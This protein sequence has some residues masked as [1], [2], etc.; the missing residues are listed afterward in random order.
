MIRQAILRAAALAMLCPALPAAGCNVTLDPLYPLAQCVP[1]NPPPVYLWIGP[2]ADVP[3]SCP[4]TDFHRV[5]TF[6]GHADLVPGAVTCPE[7]ACGESETKCGVPTDW[8]VVARS[9]E[10]P[11]DATEVFFSGPDNWNGICSTQVKISA[12]L[13]CPGGEPCTQSLLVGPPTAEGAPCTPM[14]AGEITKEE[15]LWTW[16]TVALGCFEHESDYCDDGQ[17]LV[18]T[19]PNDFLLCIERIGASC[20]LKLTELRTVYRDAEDDRACAECTCEPPAGNLC[21]VKV[22]AYSDQACGTAAGSAFAS[23][24]EGSVCFDVPDGTALA[25]KRAELIET[26]PGTCTPGGGE[27]VGDVHGKDPVVFCCQPEPVY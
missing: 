19:V 7:C 3:A 26:T 8:T 23:S 20:P 5:K 17:I 21:S 25:S 18:Y 10:E 14:T 24:N 6:E 22:T 13:A 16:Q 15:P 9:C 2:A 1:T 4:D 11:P 12:D 27:P